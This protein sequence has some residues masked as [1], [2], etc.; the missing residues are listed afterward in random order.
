MWLAAVIILSILAII[1]AAFL[2]V[3]YDSR[4]YFEWLRNK[5]RTWDVYEIYRSDRLFGS[6]WSCDRPVAV[7][8][9]ENSKHALERYFKKYRKK[10]NEYHEYD[11]RTLRETTHNWG[12][13]LVKNTRTGFKRYFH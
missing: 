12:V 4:H 3:T 11:G 5:M 2:W 8:R 1:T 9:A 6:F 7:I 10:Y 13:F